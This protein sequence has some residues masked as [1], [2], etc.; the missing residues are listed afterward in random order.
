MKKLNCVLFGVCFVITFAVNIVVAGEKSSKRSRKAQETVKIKVSAWGPT[1]AEVQAAM[2]RVEKSRAVQ[3]VLENTKYRLISFDYIESEYDKSKP[4]QSPTNF[5][6][7][8]YDYTNDRTFTA[9]GDFANTKIVTVRE[10][11]F[12]PGVSSQELAEAFEMVKKDAG[13]GEFYRQKQLKIFEAMPPVS[14]LDGE[15]LVNVGIK[16]LPD[17]ENQ[18]IGISFKNNRIVRYKDNAPLTSLAAD[19]ACGINSANQGNTANGTAGQYQLT[20]RLN[21]APLW[22]MLFIRPSASSGNSQERSGIEVRDV[23]YK[24]KSVLKRGH[25]PI[26]NVQYEGDACGPYR[27]W[28]YSEGYFNAPTEGAIDAAPGVRI[29]APGRVAQTSLDSGNDLG[30]FAGVAVYTQNGETI[31]VSEMD[32]G[33]YRYIMEWR[34]ANDG[35]IRPRYGFGATNSTCVCNSH[36][37]NVYWRFD[38]DIVSPTNKVFQLERGGKFI[39][40]VK[41]ETA[42]LRSYQTNRSFLIQNSNGGEAYKVVTN[43]SDG[44]ANDFSVGDFWLLKYRAG[45]GGEP[46]EIDDPNG[47]EQKANFAPWLNNESLLNQDVVL[48]YS[49]HFAHHSDGEHLL[50][51]DRSG[52]VLTGSHVVGPDLRPVRW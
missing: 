49:G 33:W 17:G 16:I 34:F 29:L 36:Q 25:A 9:E 2:L 24:G 28:Q 38:F 5:R 14:V 40:P 37:H 19:D 13:L 6:I 22:E 46:D 27:D 21:N 12:Q 43:L 35:T 26:L 45:I 23:K 47:D 4:A 44:E 51:P 20:V 41:N 8:F 15:R 10:E 42:R 50:S 7:V 48:W 30:N 52:T 3:N 32:A 18:V 31:L 39:Q 1:Q 11:K